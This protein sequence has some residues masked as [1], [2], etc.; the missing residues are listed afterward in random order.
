MTERGGRENEE[1]GQCGVL[2]RATLDAL[3][4]NSWFPA[5]VPNARRLHVRQ[6]EENM[7]VGFRNKMIKKWKRPFHFSR[8]ALQSVY[9]WGT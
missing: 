9:A 4:C 3:E 6:Q 1:A 8:N 5:D 7:V 2:E